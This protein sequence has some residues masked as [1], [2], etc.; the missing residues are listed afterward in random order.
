MQ[1]LAGQV[2][3]L[4]HREQVGMRGEQQAVVEAQPPAGFHLVGNFTKFGI[5]VHE[6]KVEG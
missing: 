5:D 1:P 6:D 2:G 4:A 3:N